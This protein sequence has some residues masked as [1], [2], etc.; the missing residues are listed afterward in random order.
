MMTDALDLIYLVSCTVNG[1]KPDL[2]RC[3]EMDISVIFELAQRHFFD[4]RG[5]HGAFSGSNAACVFYRGT[6]Q[7]STAAFDVFC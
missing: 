1:Q 2:Q 3:A 7:S 6:M 4:N 5:C